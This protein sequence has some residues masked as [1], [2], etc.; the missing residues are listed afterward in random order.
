MGKA[1][2]LNLQFLSKNRSSPGKASEVGLEDILIEFEMNK[3][4]A[5]SVKEYIEDLQDEI[6]LQDEIELP[7]ICSSGKE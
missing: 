5:L 6:A 1:V 3:A 4:E 7:E 2:P